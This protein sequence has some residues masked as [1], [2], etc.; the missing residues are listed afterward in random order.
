MAELQGGKLKGELRGGQDALDYWLE[1]EC[2]AGLTDL[3]PPE[4]WPDPAPDPGAMPGGWWI[5]PALALG[6]PVWVMIFR[7]MTGG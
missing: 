5:A 4:T 6:L 2:A 3:V 1:Q 7:A